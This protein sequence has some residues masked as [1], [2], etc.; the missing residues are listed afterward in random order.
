MA[1]ETTPTASVTSTV[2]P[3]TVLSTPES[4][5]AKPS[6]PT[7]LETS[8]KEPTPEQKAV[9]DAADAANKR[10]MEADE[11]TLSAEDKAKKLELVKAQSLANADKVPEKYEFKVPEGMTIDSM[12]VEAFT[13]LFKE[14]GLSQE[15]AQKLVDVYAPFVKQQ[16]EA[17]RQAALTEYK[18]MVSGWEKESV[19]ELG[20]NGSDAKQELAFAAKG[21][22]MFAT[23]EL[24]KLFSTDETGLGNHVEVVKFFAKVGKAISGDKLADGKS[25]ANDSSEDAVARRMYPTMNK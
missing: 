12:A 3:A 23:P 18:T 13:P 6:N 24:I 8:G 10:L 15:K 7:L 19:A 1:E 21:R 2:Q 20:K 16:V 9:K 4:S 17:T 5:E 14:L 22:D 11:S 25:A